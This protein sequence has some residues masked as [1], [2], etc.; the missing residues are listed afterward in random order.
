MH[1]CSSTISRTRPPPFS[2][3]RVED[4][5]GIYDIWYMT[6]FS[7]Y[8]IEIGIYLFIYLIELW[9]MA[10]V[11]LLFLSL[12]LWQ[13]LSLLLCHMSYTETYS[14]TL[15]SQSTHYV[16]EHTAVA[17]ASVIVVWFITLS[18]LYISLLKLIL[19]STHSLSLR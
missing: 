11:M 8:I 9:V 13:Y 4:D 6:G 2:V 15:F 1:S 7:I 17:Q 19:Y 12:L 18:S 14:S 5:T 3:L 16:V 10:S